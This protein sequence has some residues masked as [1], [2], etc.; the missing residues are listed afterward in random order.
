MYI[1]THTPYLTHH[2]PN[3]PPN[4]PDTQSQHKPQFIVAVPRLFETIYRG[5]QQKFATEKGAKRAL[6]NFFTKARTHN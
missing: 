1:Y 3:H 4:P 6:I 2:P 5:V